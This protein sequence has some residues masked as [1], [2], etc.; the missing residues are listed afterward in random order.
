MAVSEQYPLKGRVV[1]VEAGQVIIN[2]GK[3]HGLKAGQ[4]FNVLGQGE[5]I[6]HNGRVLGHRDTVLGRLT[7]TQVDELLAHARLSDAK[8]PL[9][10][11]LRVIARNE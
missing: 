5:A 7:V 1:S 9:A 8:G 11:N 2:L 4:G 3:K 6:E 10:K